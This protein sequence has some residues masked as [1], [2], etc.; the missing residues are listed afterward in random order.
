MEETEK[1]T[2]TVERI[3]FRS[4][5]SDY[6]VFRVRREDDNA[7]MT[8][9]GNGDIPFIG[10]RL[11]V[12]GSSVV[13]KKY[14]RQFAASSWQRILPD[15][16]EGIEHF[17]GS[18]A[19]EGVGPALA[20]RIV[21]AFGSETMRVMTEEPERLLDI[22]GIGKK[23]LA[24]ISESLREEREINELAVLLETHRV[25]GRYTKR[26]LSQYGADAAYVLEHEPYRMIM[27]IDGIGF[28][29]ADQIALAFGTDP[30][31]SERLSAGL[32]FI[33]RDMMTNGHVCIPRDE[34][35]AGAANILGAEPLQLSEVL[36]EAI[37]SGFLVAEDYGGETYV[38]T[39]EAYEAE[40]R[41]AVR[42]REM[43]AMNPPQM[44]THIQLFLD[45]RE[46]TARFRLADKQ[47]EAVEQ[48]LQSGFSVITG[49]PGTG[50]TT[51]VRTIIALAEQEG[52]DILLCAPTGRAA[53]R[54]AETTARKAK[55]IHR[56][57]APVGYVGDKQVFEYNAE[58]PLKAD[59]LIVDEV[60]MLDLELTDNLLQAL[61][62]HCRCVFVGDADQLASVGAGAVLHDIIAAGTV[63]VV[64]LETVFRQEEGGVI[65]T[66][67]HRINRGAMPVVSRD[68]EFRFLEIKEEHSGA[69]AIAEL[70][71]AETEK[72]GGDKFA[73]QVLSPMY[74]Q[75]C[76]VD[77]L[78]KL[79]QKQ[80]N[81][82]APD[83]GEFRSGEAV[84]RV[85]DKVMQKQ[86]N[87]E[88]GIFNGD[89]GEIFAASDD[90]V[91]VR[92]PEQDVKYTGAELNEITLAYAVTVHKSQ[93]SEYETVIIVLTNSHAVMLQRNLFYTAVTRA[94][95]QVILVGTKP[96]LRRAVENTRTSRRHTLLAQRLKGEEIC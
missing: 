90:F 47:R 96:A 15:T 74:R 20:G 7:F 2:G 4:P 13:H 88:K 41:V 10:D 93:G 31:S 52:L 49:G 24:V 70:Y 16:K 9:T 34:L 33:L 56:L 46:E 68:G 1:I 18:G 53:K 44:H 23:K 77:A 45:R 36:D 65:V 43:A 57:L 64:R 66:N 48:S 85:G 51:V 79:I 6:V 27:E 63:P 92:Y 69:D 11:A 95:K 86:N 21:R 3:L 76:G 37:L 82:P 26:L 81:P 91:Y 75:A 17:L 83:K 78:N 8:V 5:D 59:L 22:Q 30:L 32:Q 50:K 87:Y 54:L 94:K 38:Y 40:L 71:A 80:M 84:F 61:E 55:T 62:A 67:A 19:V 12:S 29:T 89:S 72:A 35:I 14:G 28:K 58:K 60:S 42:I 39:A 25:S 73:V